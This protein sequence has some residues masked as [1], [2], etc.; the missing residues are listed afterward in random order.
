MCYLCYRSSSASTN[1]RS[2]GARNLSQALN[3]PSDS[4]A[5]YLKD[6]VPN[7]IDRK[8]ASEDKDKQGMSSNAA[9]RVQPIKPNNI[10]RNSASV[11]STSSAVG[12]Y[13]SSTDPVHVPSP[14]SRSS[15]VVGA[16][17]REVGVV[18]VRRQSSDNKVKQSFVPSSSY[19]VGKDGTSAADS[20]Q[21]VGAASKTEQL[22]QTNVT[23]PS[24]SG[25]PVSRSSLN[26]QYNNRQHQQLVG[27]QRGITLKRHPKYDF[28]L[29]F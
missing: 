29:N 5:R 26:N 22:N 20:F 9:G 7:I 10:H 11:A 15:G 12:V 27:H 2:S 21:S 25:I 17:R 24:L 28:N 19:V 8:I 16:I 6:S 3:G 18:G 1:H 23:E 13:S 4:H 14:D